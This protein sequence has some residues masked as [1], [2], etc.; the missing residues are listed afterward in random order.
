MKPEGLGIEH[1]PLVG[2]AGDE[3]WSQVRVVVP[4][5]DDELESKGMLAVVIKVKNVEGA[6]GAGVEL[7]QEI[8]DSFQKRGEDDGWEWIRSIPDLLTNKGG[9]GVVV[10]VVPVEE[11]R[12][13]YVAGKGEMVVGLQRSQDE[14]LIWG[15]GQEK[16]V[17][18]W[19]QE[20]DRVLLGTGEFYDQIWEKLNLIVGEEKIEE[21]GARI[22]ASESKGLLAGIVLEVGEWQENGVVEEKVEK[23]VRK[24]KKVRGG[25]LNLK[26]K[27]MIRELFA[28][29][30]REWSLRIGV[31]FLVIFVISVGVGSWQKRKNEQLQEFRQVVEPIEYKLEE[32]KKLVEVNPVRARNLMLEVRNEVSSQKGRFEESKEGKK[33]EELLS[34]VEGVWR[35][36]SGERDLKAEKWLDLSVVKEGV[37]VKEMAIEDDK[38]WVVD[39]EESLLLISLEDKSSRVMAGGEVVEDVRAVADELVGDR[40]SIWQVSEKGGEA[41]KVVEIEGI[42]LV[43][44]E[45]FAN[46][47]YLLA[48]EGVFKYPG[49]EDGYGRRRRYLGAG[50]EVEVGK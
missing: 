49:L 34:K 13:L 44:V 24:R 3:N 37:E 43:D 42:E 45:G 38:L 23:K 50:E 19:L 47:I 16:G 30:R 8:V 7:L 6:A 14:S 1:Y 21:A 41:K 32:A 48:K 9:E 10:L 2:A 46:N 22:A 29:D 4:F 12:A 17:S 25:G 35:E 39:R 5:E 40:E 11:K 28:A 15:K 26:K 20:E 36:V 27:K 18:G 33:W 31:V